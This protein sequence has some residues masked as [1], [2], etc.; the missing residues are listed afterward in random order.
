MNLKNIKDSISK[1]IEA[2]IS[3]YR[4]VRK[5]EEQ[6]VRSLFNQILFVT[7]VVGS[8][9]IIITILSII[10]DLVVKSI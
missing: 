2:M 10:L 9:G 3:T 7:V 5:P 6:Q 1:E 8:F 4:K